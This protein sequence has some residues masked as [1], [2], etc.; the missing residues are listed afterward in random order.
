MKKEIWTSDEKILWV[1]GY[2][3]MCLRRKWVDFLR[4]MEK[5]NSKRLSLK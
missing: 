1:I 4:G 2:R 3:G 5:M